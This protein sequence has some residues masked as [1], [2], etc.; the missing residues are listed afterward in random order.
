M[1][2]FHRSTPTMM[3]RLSVTHMVFLSTVSVSN[4]LFVAWEKDANLT[5]D[6][7]FIEV[8]NTYVPRRFGR[9]TQEF[10]NLTSHSLDERCQ[11]GMGLSISWSLNL[12]YAGILGPRFGKES[13]FAARGIFPSELLYVPLSFSN[14]KSL[15]VLRDEGTNLGVVVLKWITFVEW[16]TVELKLDSLGGRTNKWEVRVTR[17]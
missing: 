15:K 8:K 10:R 12:P 2:S 6:D 3:C 4:A 5:S 14:F 16:N 9:I 1:Y 11:K 7:I 17:K 13:G